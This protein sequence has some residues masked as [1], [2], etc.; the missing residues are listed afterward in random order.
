M[1]GSYKQLY[2]LIPWFQ[3]GA[4]SAGGRRTTVFILEDQR[5]MTTYG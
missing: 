3:L 5:K 2:F 1:Q 4:A